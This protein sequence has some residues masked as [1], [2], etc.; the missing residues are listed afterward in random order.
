MKVGECNLQ[1]KPFARA[2]SSRRLAW[3]A[4]PR[5]NLTTMLLLFLFFFFFFVEKLTPEVINQP[6]HYPLS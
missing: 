2:G 4:S 3:A 1:R 5:E 6:T